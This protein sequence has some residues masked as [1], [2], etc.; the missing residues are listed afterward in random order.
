[1]NILRHQITKFIVYTCVLVAAVGV[2]HAS[3]IAAVLDRYILLEN[4]HPEYHAISSSATTKTVP[5]DVLLEP[6]VN[7]ITNS[8][9]TREYE[10]GFTITVNGDGSITY[11]GTNNSSDIA[12]VGITGYGWNLPGASYV[13][14]DSLNGIPVSTSEFAICVMARKYHVGGGIDYTAIADMSTLESAF[15]TTDYSQYNDY[16]VQLVIKPGY[17]S[18]GITIYP[19]LTT[20]EERTTQYQPC[21]LSNLQIYEEQDVHTTTYNYIEMSKRDYLDLSDK[22]LTLLNR[23]I[24]HQAPV[25][26]NWTTID[27]GDGTGVYY[28]ENDPEL[29]QYG[30]LNDVGQM[31]LLYGDED[32]IIL[33]DLPLEQTTNLVSYLEILNNPDYTILIATRDDGVSALTDYT[34]QLLEN[35]GVVTPL[36]EQPE[37]SPRTYYG[38][39]YYAVLNPGQASVE[40]ISTGE[41][42]YTGTTRD[43]LHSFTLHSRGYNVGDGVASITIDGTEYA[44]NRRGMNIVVYDNEAG[45]V[46]DS[47]AFDT[48]SGLCVYRE[49]QQ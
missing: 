30:E 18:N 42:N 46:V 31:G 3:G 16:Y 35:L 17:T 9:T 28:P 2:Y 39:S 40:E 32:S 19:M 34:F 43:G 49:L 45:E 7:R 5:Y 21:L 37:Y 15:F 24:R 6:L 11:S 14:S 10:Q 13:L 25:T 12:Y 47:V 38:Q 44:M 20:Y 8:L 1:M 29:L 23:F 27:F 36:T 4:T 48:S 41:L 22:D 26:G 33:A